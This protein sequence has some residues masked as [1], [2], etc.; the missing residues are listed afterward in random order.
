[1]NILT[2]FRVAFRALLSNK[3]RSFLTML[4]VIIGVSSVITLISIGAGLKQTIVGQLN[5][6]GSDLIYVMPGDVARPG[7]P[8]GA[9]GFKSLKFS[10][11]DLLSQQLTGVR[12]VV[13]MAET[14]AA[15]TRG[16]EKIKLADII[17]TTANYS[18]IVEDNVI[19]GSF[20]SESQANSGAAVVVAGQTIRQELFNGQDP[21]GQQITIADKKFTVVGELE[22]MGAKFGVDQDSRV[23]VPF[24]SLQSSGISNPTTIIIK[25]EKS[26]D[27]PN[28]ADAA[29]RILRQHYSSEGFSV[30]TQEETLAIVDTVLGAVSSALIGIAAISLLVGGI[31]ISNIMLVS[32]TERTREIGL[33]KALGAKPRDILYQFLV[34]AVVLT[35]IGGL[36]GVALG[37]LAGFAVGVAIPSLKPSISIGTISLAAGFS[38][39]VGIVFGVFPALRAAKLDPIEALRYE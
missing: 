24:K 17:S 16:N 11:A 21:I 18:L 1:M 12:G 25:T 33:R 2:S 38:A 14:F 31:G 22:K 10:D 32:I 28:I 36:I 34:E 39:L 20:F 23:Y 6:F 3:L 4:G 30:L 7:G 19:A 27:I 29:K 15:I 26:D 5:Q 8:T 9:L 13:P 35:V 37:Y